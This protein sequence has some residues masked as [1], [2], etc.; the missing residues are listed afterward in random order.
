MGITIL[1]IIVGILLGLG[2]AAAYWYFQPPPGRRRP[3][4]NVRKSNKIKQLLLPVGAAVAVS[5]LAWFG[6]GYIFSSSDST[7]DTVTNTVTQQVP[8]PDESAS[9]PDAGPEQS[10]ISPAPERPLLVANSPLV[11]AAMQT[12]PVAS[13]LDAFGVGRNLTRNLNPTKPETPPDSTPK[14]EPEPAAPQVTAAVQP[15]SA[16]QPKPEPEPEAA[17]QPKPAPEAAPQTK[18]QT[19]VEPVPAEPLP[20]TGVRYTVHL[21]SF[22]VKEN[23]EQSMTRLRTAGVPAFIS[24]IELNSKTFYRLMAGS[25]ATRS[26]AQAYGRNLTSRGLTKDLGDF[27]IKPIVTGQDTG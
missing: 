16:T 17:P 1:M 19:T 2:L 10:P 25:F 4:P 7:P 24:K 5:L 18:P 6:L 21:A 14:P 8:N 11:K 3:R 22:G 26:E 15:E 27:T 9:G 13:Q 23:A 12:S 20:T